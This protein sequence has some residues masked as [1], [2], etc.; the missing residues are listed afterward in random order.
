MDQSLR[1]GLKKDQKILWLEL[2]AKQRSTL[3]KCKEMHPHAEPDHG[4][5][6]AMQRTALHWLLVPKYVCGP[7]KDLEN[8][9]TKHRS[10]VAIYK[11]M[12]SHA[13]PDH[14]QPYVMQRTTLHWLRVPIKESNVLIL[15]YKQ[16]GVHLWK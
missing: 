1:Y 13:E 2:L 9:L 14:G 11:E 10:T 7:K 3:A 15:P 4:Q 8:L 5:P 12:Y 6:Y 16:S